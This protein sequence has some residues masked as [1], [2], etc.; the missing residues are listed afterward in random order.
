[1][2]LSLFLIIKKAMAISL[3]IGICY[4]ITEFAAHTLKILCARKS[5]GAVTARAAKPLLDRLNNFLIF[6]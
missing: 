1:M 2:K 5:A 3:I 6:V 4:L